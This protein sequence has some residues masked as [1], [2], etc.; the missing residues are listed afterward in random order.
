MT[1]FGR[2]SVMR[3]RCHAV[4]RL[5]Q[6]LRA[7]SPLKELAKHVVPFPIRHRL[8]MRAIDANLKP[9]R[10]PP[11]DATL[12]LDLRRHYAGEMR[13]LETIIGRDLSA[14]YAGA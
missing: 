2:S 5:N 14:W 11:L 7:R 6:W 8:K 1:T 13:A 4:A 3:L 12:A 10:M 9:M